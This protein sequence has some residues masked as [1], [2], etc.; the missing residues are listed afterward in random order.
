MGAKY[1]ERWRNLPA[2]RSQPPMSADESN[3]SKP[4][5]DAINVQEEYELARW[6]RHYGLTMNQLKVIVQK[7]GPWPAAVEEELKTSSSSR[8]P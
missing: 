5:H 2:V 1:Y 8:R 6:A 3:I 4:A 7:V